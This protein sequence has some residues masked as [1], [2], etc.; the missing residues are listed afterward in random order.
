M[1]MQCFQTL[2]ISGPLYQIQ[3]YHYHKKTASGNIVGIDG[4]LSAGTVNAISIG[5]HMVWYQ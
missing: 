2:N 3:H 4:I 1:V 5:G